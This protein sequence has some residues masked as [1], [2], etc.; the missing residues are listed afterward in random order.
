MP[1]YRNDNADQKTIFAGGKPIR[2]GEVEVLDQYVYDPDLVL[3][4]H[5][6]AATKAL[7]PKLSKVDILI[8]DDLAI[9]DGET[10][11]AGPFNMQEFDFGQARSFG[12]LVKGSADHGGV[13]LTA[14]VHAARIETSGESWPFNPT[15]LAPISGEALTDV[16]RTFDLEQCD[17]IVFVFDSSGGDTTITEAQLII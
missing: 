9:A 16:H 1:K 11:K 3:V 2:Y 13:E 17:A 6:P 15:A 7:D 5:Y 8:E 12:L 4:S 14:N 10:K